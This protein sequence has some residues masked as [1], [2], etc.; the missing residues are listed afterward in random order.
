MQHTHLPWHEALWGNLQQR[1]IAQRLPHA[2][3]L[4]GA[5]GLG[6]H[7]FAQHLAKALLCTAIDQH[8]MACGHCRSCRLFQAGSHPD[9]RLLQPVEEGKALKIDQVRELCSFL[10]YTPQ[11]GGYKVAL[12]QPADAM[13]SNAANSLLKTL[14]EPPGACLLI[15]VTSQPGRLPATVRS[16]CQRVTFT[17]PPT[18]MARAWLQK[19][20]P[21]NLDAAVLLEVAGGAPL[22]ALRYAESERWQRRR[23]LAENY[24]KVLNGQL[25]PVH[26]AAAWMQGDLAENLRWLVTWQSDAIRLNIMLNPPRLQNPDLRAV[27][28]N[29]AQRQPPQR[30]FAQLDST[31]RLYTLCTTTQVR[32]DLLLEHFLSTLSSEPPSRLP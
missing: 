27:L 5:A 19:R 20:L 14:D 11:Y 12:L 28:Q 4:T 16:R 25:D 29:W 3:L 15:L 8:G 31:Q 6:K 2:L 21:A 18:S 23:A 30:L 17:P 9:Y 13:N 26:A 22:L 24:A 1:R 10:G 7:Q 32:A